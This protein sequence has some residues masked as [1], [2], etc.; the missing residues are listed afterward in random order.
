MD[1]KAALHAALVTSEKF[2]IITFSTW[3]LLHQFETADPGH[4]PDILVKPD[5]F[6][7]IHEKEPGT[8]GFAHECF[9]EVDRSSETQ[10]TLV[11]RA[12]AYLEYY[13]SGGFAIRNGVSSDRFKEFPFRVL[14]VLKTAERRNNLAERLAQRNP[15]ILTQAWLTTLAEVK[16]DPLG[17]IWLR[18]MDYRNATTGTPF[19]SKQSNQRFDYRRQSERETFVEAKVQKLRLLETPLP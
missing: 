13:K 5:G 4:G 7:H 19:Y 8:K 9:L 6:I 16:H 11:N 3:P 15:P 17:A 2:S 14:I 1:V 12:G 18:P 10:D